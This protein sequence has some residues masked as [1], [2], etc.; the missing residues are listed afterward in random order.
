MGVIALT[1]PSARLS[2]LAQYDTACRALAAAKTTDEVKDIRDRAEAMRAYARQAKNRQLEVDAAEI[3]IRA[4]RRL[5]ELIQAQKETTGL[6]TGAAGIGRPESAVPEEYRTQPPTLA[7]AGIDKK[8][9]SRAQ[10]LAAVPEAK[11]EGLMA[12]WRDRV[13]QETERVTTAL[14]GG[15]RGA[16]ALGPGPVEW[17]TPELFLT[18]ARQVLGEFD[19]D[20]ASCPAAQRNVRARVYFTTEDDGLTQEWY[21][22]VW[23]NPPYCDADKFA[24]KLLAELGAGRVTSAILLVNAYIDT[25]W[26]QRAA[27]V[28]AAICFPLGRVYFERP[29]DDHARQPRFGSALLYFGLQMERFRAAF[30]DKGLIVIPEAGDQP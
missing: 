19:L 14:I 21:G 11:F 29:G 2:G 18:C 23:C 25:R 24:D 26:F 6:A 22:R 10:R 5:G 16:H 13:A 30:A 15:G 7:E 9:S 28:C 8:L 3:R 20:P 17:Y 1:Q 12:D 4:E 27:A